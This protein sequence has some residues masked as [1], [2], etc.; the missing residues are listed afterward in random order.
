MASNN[1]ADTQSAILLLDE[2]QFSDIVM[3]DPEAN[4][5]A[6]V[7][8]MSVEAIRAL[9]R[10][11]EIMSIIQ[12]ESED[13]SCDQVSPFLLHF[14]YKAAVIHLRML[15]SDPNGVATTGFDVLKRGLRQLGGRWLAASAYA[16]LK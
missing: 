6:A 1:C 12:S 10:A 14:V 7:L 8:A 5:Q 2:Q 4:N 11:V 3:G 9:R 15:R 13:Q 16:T